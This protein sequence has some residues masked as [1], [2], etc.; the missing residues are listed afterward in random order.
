MAPV[1]LTSENFEEVVSSN[2]V[3]IVDFWASWCGPCKRFAPIFAAAA[4]KHS[5]VT[6]A[7]VNTETERE[8]AT[9][10]KIQSIPTVVVFREQIGLFA[11]PG[12]LNAGDLDKLLQEIKSVN[13]DEIRAEIA[14]E[15]MPSS[16]A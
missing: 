2:D 8:L 13:M 1:E 15:G 9:Y 4:E 3:V 16:D 6:F 11:Q 7:K 5:D 14:A 10:F 12:M